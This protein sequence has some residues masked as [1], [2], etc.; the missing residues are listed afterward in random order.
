VEVEDRGG[1][2]QDNSH[3]SESAFS[4][5]LSVQITLALASVTDSI[6]RDE[7]QT[8]DSVEVMERFY[9]GLSDRPLQ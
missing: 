5:V 2:S 7:L 3:T 8:L 4:R 9:S 6:G 1:R